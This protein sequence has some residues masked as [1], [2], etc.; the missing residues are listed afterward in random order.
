M[1]KTCLITKIVKNENAFWSTLLPKKKMD[2]KLHNFTKKD[3]T[4]WS[5]HENFFKYLIIT[6]EN[7][8][9]T[10]PF[11]IIFGIFVPRKNTQ[12]NENEK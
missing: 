11:C 10:A 12:K 9:K 1:L 2:K 3:E 8:Q 6:K 5:N 7:D 4:G